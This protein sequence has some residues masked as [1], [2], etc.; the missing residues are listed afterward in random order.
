VSGSVVIPGL[1][2]NMPSIANARIPVAYQSARTA[3][4]RCARIDGCKDWADKAEAL[5]SYAR[6]AG[7]TELRKMADRIKARAI[8]RCGELIKELAPKDTAGPPRKNNYDGTDTITRS[9]AAKAAGLSERQ[10]NTALRVSNI[11]YDEFE[12]AV[13]SERPPTVTQ[14]AEL[15]KKPAPPPSTAHLEEAIHEPT[16]G[17]LTV[18]MPPGAYGARAPASVDG[19]VERVV[20]LVERLLRDAI[21]AQSELG[22]AMLY[23]IIARVQAMR[24]P[25][26]ALEG[27]NRHEALSRSK[28]GQQGVQEI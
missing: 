12:E 6:Q 17:V 13:G 2:A 20:R 10:K 26:E 14:L 11:P 18:P 5:A 3:I 21:P 15:G 28:P 16:A 8:R 24:K 27:R 19:H 7:D 25:V 9:G 22:D 23:H 1:P 4:A